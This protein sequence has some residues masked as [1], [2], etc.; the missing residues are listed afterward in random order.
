M[1]YLDDIILTPKVHLKRLREVYEKLSESVLKLNPSKCEFF[2]N[3]L[4]YLGYVVS[5]NGI[6][7]NKKKIEAFPNWQIPVT[8]TDQR[9]FVG[10]TNYYRWFIPMYAHIARLLNL[11]KSGENASRRNKML[12]LNEASDKLRELYINTPV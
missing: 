1:I 9:S 11:L 2:R 3:S 6:E 5:G 12:Y 7:M 8:V 10:F 4:S